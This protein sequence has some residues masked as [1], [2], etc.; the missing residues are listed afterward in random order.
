MIQIQISVYLIKVMKKEKM[1]DSFKMIIVVV[2]IVTNFFNNQNT[3][4]FD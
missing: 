2:C 4:V 3:I 1:N